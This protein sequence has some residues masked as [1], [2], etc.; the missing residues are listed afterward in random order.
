MLV[1]LA[2]VAALSASRPIAPSATVLAQRRVLFLRQSHA[3][4][5]AA[6]RTTGIGLGAAARHVKWRGTS[7]ASSAS[8]FTAERLAGLAGLDHGAAR[9]RAGS[10]GRRGRARHRHQ[11]RRSGM[12][13]HQAATRVAVERPAGLAGLSAPPASV[14][15]R[16]GWSRGAACRRTAQRLG[17]S[18]AVALSERGG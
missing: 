14:A 4:G 5:L 10:R 15:Q 11:S 8:R 3:E 1:P 12:E 7:P 9:H 2:T 6:E 18:I 16:H 17:T 13:W